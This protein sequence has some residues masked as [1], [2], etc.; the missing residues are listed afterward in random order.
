MFSVV[1]GEIWSWIVTLVVLQEEFFAYIYIYIYMLGFEPRQ[2][3]K[4]QQPLLGAA[5]CLMP[6][7]N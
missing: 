1:G 4:T 2:L 7:K 3:E 6:L 5:R